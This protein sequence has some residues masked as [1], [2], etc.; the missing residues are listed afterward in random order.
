E[1]TKLI[2]EYEA[3]YDYYYDL[4]D[5]DNETD[6]EDESDN[7]EENELHETSVE[8]S[9]QVQKLSTEEQIF[10][11]GSGT[12]NLTKEKDSDSQELFKLHQ[13][14]MAFSLPENSESYQ[15]EAIS[16]YNSQEPI[17]LK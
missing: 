13:Q 6:G 4:F 3:K 14:I 2:A 7:K 15:A 16:K 1:R 17:I 8:N 12:T 11:S 5:S 9:Q 10:A